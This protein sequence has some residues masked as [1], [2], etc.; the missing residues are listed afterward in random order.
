VKLLENIEYGIKIDV[1][2]PE[3]I[4]SEIFDSQLAR[5]ASSFTLNV[6]EDLRENAM[7]LFAE[8]SPLM[9]FKHFSFT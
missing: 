4:I 7:T 3:K 2:V 5:Q 9:N 8:K 6:I 1:E